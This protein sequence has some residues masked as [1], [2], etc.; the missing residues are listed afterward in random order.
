MRGLH[1]TG[2]QR[3]RGEHGARDVADAADAHARAT[4][5]SLDVVADGA[6]ERPFDDPEGEHV[7]KVDR[8]D[9]GRPRQFLTEKRADAPDA[10]SGLERRVHELDAGDR[11]H[12]IRLALGIEHDARDVGR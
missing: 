5:R 1:R 8:L 2:N 4:G 7:R 3:G 11:L 10:C 6:G 9:L 12:P